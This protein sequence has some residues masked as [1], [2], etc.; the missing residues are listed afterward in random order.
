MPRNA[1]ECQ[2]KAKQK[3]NNSQRYV[4]HIIY[5]NAYCFCCFE[6]LNIKILKFVT[7]LNVLRLDFIHL[8]V[9]VVFSD[10][11]NILCIEAV[12][13]LL[14]FPKEC[15]RNAKGMPKGMPKECQRNAKGMPKECQ[16]NA[17]GMP[18]ECQRNLKVKPKEHQRNANEKKSLRYV[19]FFAVWRP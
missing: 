4:F 6:A 5:R 12:L 8:S 13:T 1:K 14:T 2:R 15:Q 7:S 18:K 10:K 3:P 16:R 19:L 17:K 11:K 9:F